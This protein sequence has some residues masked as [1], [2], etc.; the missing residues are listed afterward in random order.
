MAP[1]PLPTTGDEPHSVAHVS[2]A[3]AWPLCVAGDM[4]PLALAPSTLP[5][6]RSWAAERTHGA[7]LSDR[8]E[9]PVS[10]RGRK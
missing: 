7:G 1:Y 6:G 3:A 8:W 9:E 2:R 10:R 5:H 4:V